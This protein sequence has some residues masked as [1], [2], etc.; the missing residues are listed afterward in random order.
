MKKKLLALALVIVLMLTFTV[1]ASAEGEG[2][3]P[4]WNLWKLLS[5]ENLNIG[6][7]ISIFVSTITT[8]FQVIGGIGK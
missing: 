7:L 3:E 8:F 6:R 1:I 5:L 4:A 2:T